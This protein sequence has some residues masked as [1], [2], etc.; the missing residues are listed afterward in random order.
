MILAANV[1]MRDPEFMQYIFASPRFKIRQAERVPKHE[2][3]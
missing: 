2:I 3:L 1:A